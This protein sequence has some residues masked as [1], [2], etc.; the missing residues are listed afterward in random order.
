MNQLSVDY[1]CHII[2]LKNTYNFHTVHM[3]LVQPHFVLKA[4]CHYCHVSRGSDGYCEFTHEGWFRTQE[5]HSPY[6]PLGDHTN[7]T[8]KSF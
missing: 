1:F 3:A 8:G 6:G 7:G 2:K 5:Q 4:V